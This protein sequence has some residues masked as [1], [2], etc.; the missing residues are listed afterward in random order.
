MREELSAVAVQFAPAAGAGV[1]ANLRL[2]VDHIRDGAGGGARLV[3]FPELS[4]SG[5]PVDGELTTHQPGPDRRLA[6]IA[7]ATRDSGTYA[8]VGFAERGAGAATFNSA[9]LF[10]PGGLIGVV[11]KRHL[12][13]LER[14]WFAPG[15]LPPVF[16][17]QVG[18]VAI[19]ICYD[20]WFPEYV[21]PL[22]VRGAEIIVNI[23]SIWAGGRRGGIGD[24]AAKRRYWRHIPTARALDTQSYV[25]ACN[26]CGSHSFGGEVGTWSRLG[27]SRIVDPAGF[28]M[29]RA[30]ADRAAVIAATLRGSR[31]RRARRSIGLLADTT[32]SPPSRVAGV[33]REP[34][35]DRQVVEGEGEES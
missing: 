19:V 16:A 21:K 29:V 34:G 32:S 6:E 11:R 35:L 4:L 31:L 17:T 12:P 13:G 23:N 26:G 10:G 5:F 27:G 1:D 22:A 8:V 15:E 33:V 24:R 3:V 7:R 14:S 9:G 2:I 20:A 30:P 18:T 25:V 28:T